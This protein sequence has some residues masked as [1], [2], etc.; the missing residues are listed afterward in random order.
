MKRS[1]PH[2]SRSTRKVKVAALEKEYGGSSG[3]HLGRPQHIAV[4]ELF[5]PSSAYTSQ[6][7]AP[8][9]PVF[10]GVK[11][12]D[13][14]LVTHPHTTLFYSNGLGIGNGQTIQI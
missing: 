7:V 6:I 10:K 13:K 3:H 14:F 11:H 8:M 9:C 5:F 1:S 12:S 4:M 2:L